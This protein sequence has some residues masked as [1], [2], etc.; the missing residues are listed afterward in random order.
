LARRDHKVLQISE[1]SHTLNQ[2]Y[3]DFNLEDIP[4]QL[5]ETGKVYLWGMQVF[6]LS[7]GEYISATAPAHTVQID[8]LYPRDEEKVAD[9]VA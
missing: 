3:A 5:G 1:F 4:P 8:D 9:G 2:N 6:G 7:R